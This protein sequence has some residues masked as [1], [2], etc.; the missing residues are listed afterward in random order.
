M[1]EQELYDFSLQNTMDLID[2]KLSMDKIIKLREINF[3]FDFYIDEIC[4]E[5]MK[6]LAKQERWDL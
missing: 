2:G 1:S 6:R 5:F 3:S 4:E